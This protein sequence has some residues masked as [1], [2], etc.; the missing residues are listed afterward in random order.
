LAQRL[1]SSRAIN[2]GDSFCKTATSR[3][4]NVLRGV[5]VPVV[6]RSASATRPRS[7]SET[8]DTFRAAARVARRTDLGRKRFVNFSERCTCEIAFVPEHHGPRD[9]RQA[10]STLDVVA[11]HDIFARIL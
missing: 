5:D 2:G 11:D 8:C 4:E 9:I 6:D 7:Y 10:E 1:T 3:R